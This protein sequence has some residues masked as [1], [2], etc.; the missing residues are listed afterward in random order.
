MKFAAAILLAITVSARSRRPSR[1]GGGLSNKEKRE[2][3]SW[4][5]EIGKDYQTTAEFNTRAENWKKTD[6]IINKNTDRHFKLGHNKFSDKTPEEKT[7]FLS[8][9]SNYRKEAVTNEITPENEEEEEDE[10][11]F[12]SPDGSTGDD[13]Y[14]QGVM[15]TGPKS[16]TAIQEE[17]EDEDLEAASVD[18]I[19]GF[20]NKM[21]CPDGYYYQRWRRECKPCSNGC[22]T[23]KNN[24]NCSECASS[25]LTLQNR[26]CSCPEGLA[27]NAETGTCEA[28]GDGTFYDIFR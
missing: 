16:S 23:C 15:N 18:P 8:L 4:I 21:T 14:R 24:W 28:C 25:D 11:S 10:D 2:F 22:I 20:R 26:K 13:D 12:D 3:L 9:N 19:K 5:G 1:N 17:V 6:G 7:A 27:Y